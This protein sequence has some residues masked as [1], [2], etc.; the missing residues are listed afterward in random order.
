ML[1]YSSRVLEQVIAHDNHETLDWTQIWYTL[2]LK[3]PS[4]NEIQLN[5]HTI[6]IGLTT[7]NGIEG[8]DLA[9][10]VKFHEHVHIDAYLLF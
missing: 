1:N 4:S 10:P 3:A 6:H 7:D 8:P 2:L 5:M 9:P